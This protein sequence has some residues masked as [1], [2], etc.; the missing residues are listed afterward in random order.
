MLN[1][2]HACDIMACSKY[3]LWGTNGQARCDYANDFEEL[4]GVLRI[5]KKSNASYVLSYIS[6]SPKVQGPILPDGIYE[7][8]YNDY[9]LNFDNKLTQ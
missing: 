2:P 8:L 1:S 5:E 4:L 7:K 6:T 9:I 3:V